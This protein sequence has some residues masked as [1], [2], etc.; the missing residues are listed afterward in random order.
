MSGACRSRDAARGLRDLSMPCFGPTGAH[1]VHAF[2]GDALGCPRGGHGWLAPRT[3]WRLLVSSPK[4]S[5]TWSAALQLGNPGSQTTIARVWRASARPT[6]RTPK[7]GEAVC[8]SPE[9]PRSDTARRQL[10]GYRHSGR[11]DDLVHCVQRQR[12]AGTVY[13]AAESED[14]LRPRG[15]RVQV[16]GIIRA[17]IGV[18]GRPS[19]EPQGW[20]GAREKYEG[21][22]KKSNDNDF[23]TQSVRFS[24]IHLLQYHLH[25]LS[26]IVEGREPTLAAAALS[27]TTDV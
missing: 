24:R 18:H 20:R 9:R 26:L 8:V 13:L 27:I 11:G 25:A 12:V 19:V 23:V 7:S 17:V 10:R 16:A 15:R 1:T 14:L 5:L 22:I 3:P 6:P 21:T 4:L 2:P